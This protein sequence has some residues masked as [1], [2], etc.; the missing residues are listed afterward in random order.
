MSG[1]PYDDLGDFYGEE[2]TQA[3]SPSPGISAG[4]I[5]LLITSIIS[6]SFLVYVVIKRRK[7]SKRIK[8]APTYSVSNDFEHEDEELHNSTYRTFK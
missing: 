2:K 6:L 7:Q 5:V 8:K 4:A 3:P 1:E